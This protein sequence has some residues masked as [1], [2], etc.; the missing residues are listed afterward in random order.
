MSRARPPYTL[1]RNLKATTALLAAASAKEVLPVLGIR[2][3]R[4]RAKTSAAATLKVRAVRP[5]SATATV[6]GNPV[7]VALA[8]NTENVIEMTL[9]G[10]AFI[11]VEI[12]MGVGNGTVTYVD[13]FFET[14][15]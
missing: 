14:A 2:K 8:A 7:D 13:V 15:D 12:L 1:T 5:D 6:S 11:E 9:C 10:E 4:V 3:V